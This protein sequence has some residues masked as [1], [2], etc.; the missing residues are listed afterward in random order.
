MELEFPLED[1]RKAGKREYLQ[2]CADLGI[3]PIA[4]FVAKMEVS[5]LTSTTTGWAS[6]APWRS[7]NASR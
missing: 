6:R 5:T 3:V 7:Q 4:L 1:T 2:K